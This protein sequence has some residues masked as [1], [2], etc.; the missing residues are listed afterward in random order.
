MSCDIIL[1]LFLP[2]SQMLGG[3]GLRLCHRLQNAPKCLAKG[4]W[5]ENSTG[6]AF[7]WKVKELHNLN[8]RVVGK[9][10]DRRL[11][12]FAEEEVLLAAMMECIC[13]KYR[14]HNGFKP[15]YF[16]EVEKELKKRL[17]GTTF[18]AQPNIGVEGEGVEGKSNSR[19]KGLNGKSFPMYESWQFLFGKDRA[20]GDLAEDAAEVKEVVETPQ[21]EANIEVDDMLNECYT[22]T[23]ANGDTVFPYETP[24]V[25][26]STFQQAMPFQPRHEPQPILQEA[27]PM[28]P[29]AMSCQEG[30]RKRFMGYFVAV[31]CPILYSFAGGCFV[32]ILVLHAGQFCCC[33]LASFVAVLIVN[34]VLHVGLLGCYIL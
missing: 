28:L 6:L 26:I 24:F 20:T 16:N 7:L 3:S 22:P 2:M 27:M 31:I 33:M 21:D 15:G 5:V 13:D 23:F 14:A 32:A 12:T 11:W 17:L 29:Q 10:Q 8:Q 9:K 19:A 25:D 34:V 18:K 30:Q 4:S 1:S